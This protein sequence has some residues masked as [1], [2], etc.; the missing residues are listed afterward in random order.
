MLEG[1]LISE[2]LEH[3][4]EESRAAGEIKKNEEN[5]AE[6]EEDLYMHGNAWLKRYDV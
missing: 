6:A 1:F 2:I 4:V 3:K 5:G